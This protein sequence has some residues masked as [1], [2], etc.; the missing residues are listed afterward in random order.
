MTIPDYYIARVKNKEYYARHLVSCKYP[1]P[2]L[3]EVV[4]IGDKSD[5]MTHGIWGVEERS[6]KIGE[7]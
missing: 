7:E 4:M 2:S 5:A 1:Q 6:G 3:Q